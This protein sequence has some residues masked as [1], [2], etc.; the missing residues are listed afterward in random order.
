MT[1]AQFDHLSVEEKKD[2]LF[3]CCGSRAWVKDM[4]EVFPIQN[5]VDLLEYA[6]EKWYDCNPAD[7]LEAFENHARLGDRKALNAE[8]DLYGKSEQERLLAGD[9]LVIDVLKKA[10][11]KYED[12]FGY[13]FI[14]YA[15]GKTAKEL[16]EELEQRLENDPR[17]EL[18]IAASEQFKITKSRLERLF[19]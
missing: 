1:I 18:Q 16:L 19:I 17:D 3:S 11:E 7:W 8:G 14:S 5:L 6:E 9:P 4:M 15:K 12:T 2:L 10:N 13:M